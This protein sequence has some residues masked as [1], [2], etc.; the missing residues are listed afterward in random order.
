MAINVGTEIIRQPLPRIPSGLDPE[1]EQYLHA[2]HRYFE[3]LA[4][5]LNGYLIPEVTDKSADQRLIFDVSS[6]DIVWDT[7]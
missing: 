1:L 2:L 6:D 4:P 3:S 7:N 5:A